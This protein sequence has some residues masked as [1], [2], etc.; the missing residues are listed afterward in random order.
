MK[1][2]NNFQIE[3]ILTQI[4]SESF[5]W[6]HHNNLNHSFNHADSSISTTYDNSTVIIT[7]ANN[8]N[9]DDDDDDYDMMIAMNILNLWV[10]FCM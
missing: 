3:Q 2:Y 1:N 7:D 8:D 4:L 6:N 5:L 9:N 10:L